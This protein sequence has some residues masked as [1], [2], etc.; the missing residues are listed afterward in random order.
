MTS[1]NC[2]QAPFRDGGVT[3][4]LQLKTKFE[5][6]RFSVNFAVTRQ[7]RQV[8]LFWM[9][10][11]SALSPSTWCSLLPDSQ[12]I[13]RGSGERNLWSKEAEEKANAGGLEPGKNAAEQLPVGVVDNSFGQSLRFRKDNELPSPKKRSCSQFTPIRGCYE[14]NLVNFVLVFQIDVC[15]KCLVFNRILQKS[16]AW[17]MYQF[18]NVPG[19]R[20][21]RLQ[22]RR[23]TPTCFLWRRAWHRWS[24]VLNLKMLRQIWRSRVARDGSCESRARRA[25]DGLQWH[26]SEGK[27]CILLR[28]S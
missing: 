4:I 23:K 10:T 18:L 12:C 19:Q 20:P 1:I 7:H 25:A 17:W 3:S 15:V 13:E 22:P 24:L 5:F 27:I 26:I 9:K 16:E 8:F 21:L 2:W 6:V 14:T 28:T 11:V